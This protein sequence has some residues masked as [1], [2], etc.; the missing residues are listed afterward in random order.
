MG[1]INI[2]DIWEDDDEATIVQPLTEIETTY[3]TVEGRKLNIDDLWEASDEPEEDTFWGGVGNT[4]GIGY[5]AVTGVIPQPVKDYAK[6]AG[7]LAMHGLH[8][9]DIFGNPIQD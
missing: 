9:L 1:K 5:D 8:Y 3:P 2:S 4:I 7:S 6:G